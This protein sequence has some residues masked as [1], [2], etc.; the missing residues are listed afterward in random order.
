[1]LFGPLGVVPPRP[2]P[3]SAG[4]GASLDSLAGTEAAGTEAATAQLPADDPVLTSGAYMRP[5]SFGSSS[6]EQLPPVPL[7]LCCACA[8]IIRDYTWWSAVAPGS[9][10]PNGP[11]FVRHL[12]P[13]AARCNACH[14]RLLA[15]E[16]Q[17]QKTLPVQQPL[18]PLW[19]SASYL[20]DGAFCALPVMRS[21]VAGE[22]GFDHKAAPVRVAK[23]SVRLLAR[24][25]EHGAEAVRG[26]R[27][28]LHTRT[29][30]SVC[31]ISFS[32]GHSAEIMCCTPVRALFRSWAA[33]RWAFWHRAAW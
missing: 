23:R 29:H 7:R 6:A 5:T 10:S 32:R 13:S 18:R 25:M 8:E 31:A 22:G 30:T 1:M 19:R 28:A 11:R 12:G 14:Q 26:C 27:W 21:L 9:D 16:L 4:A 17:Q 2:P 20:S 15:Q 24:A 33:R 3:G